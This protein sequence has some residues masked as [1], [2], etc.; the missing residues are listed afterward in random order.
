[1]NLSRAMQIGWARL[2]RVGLLLAAIVPAHLAFAQAT[3][4]PIAQPSLKQAPVQV[5]SAQS[6]CVREAN[7]RGYAVTDTSNFQ[8]SR[9]GWSVDI[10]ARD[11][12]GQAVSGSCFVET[13]TGD[14][15]LYGFGWG[16][17]WN[18]QTSLE[19]V[20]ASTDMRYRECQLPV[21][22]RAR[23]VKRISDARCVEGE[24]W[25]QRGDRVWVDRGCRAR[26]E[27]SRG[28]GG[29][30]GGLIQCA[31]ENQLY[32]E[33]SIGN[34]YSAR[35]VRETS[36]GRCRRDSTWGTRNGVVWVTNG[37][38]GEFERI[39][40]VGHGT[41][42]GQPGNIAAVQDACRNEAR[43]LGFNVGQQFAPQAISGGYRMQM[44]LRK[45]NGNARNATCTYSNSSGRARLEM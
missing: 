13:R 42:P 27:V 28:G 31:S 19:F 25:G 41:N 4:G 2:A 10:R 24:T 5:R 20:C 40:G 36:K 18:G 9:D 44:Q 3:Q 38:R 1:M 16:D 35:L 8:Q 12:R 29:G 7:R 43:Q 32:R 14:V 15:S 37:C 11:R 45:N 34:G 6:D 39:R 26:F 30:S 33:C 22:G 17:D 23:L 21:N